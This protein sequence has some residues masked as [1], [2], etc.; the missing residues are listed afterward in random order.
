MSYSYDRTA[1]RRPRV[2]P[3]DAKAEA[4]WNEGGKTRYVTW[5]TR[6]LIPAV[7]KLVDAKND[8]LSDAL[9]ELDTANSAVAKLIQDSYRMNS[10]F[11]YPSEKSPDDGLLRRLSPVLTDLGMVTTPRDRRLPAVSAEYIKNLY[12]QLQDYTGALSKS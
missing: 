9:G 3:A 2:N 8:W 10:V 1:A 11:G 6:K 12:E 7:K 5:L 4:L